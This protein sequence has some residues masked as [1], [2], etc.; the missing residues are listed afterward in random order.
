[1]SSRVRFTKGSV[2][3]TIFRLLFFSFH[4]SIPSCSQL[5]SPYLI[6]IGLLSIQAKVDA[7]PKSLPIH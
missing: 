5:T 1:M 2:F 3:R 6:L 7:T 4:L